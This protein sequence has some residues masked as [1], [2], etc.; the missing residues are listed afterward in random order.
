M[1][2]EG[3]DADWWR[4]REKTERV[5]S[6]KRNEPVSLYV[7]TMRTYL[8]IMSDMFC[9]VLEPFCDEGMDLNREALREVI[10]AINTERKNP[11]WN[12]LPGAVRDFSTGFVEFARALEK[13]GDEVLAQHRSVIKSQYSLFTRCHSYGY[14]TG[15]NLERNT[16]FCVKKI[17]SAYRA[18]MKAKGEGVDGVA[19]TASVRAFM[20]PKG[21]CERCPFR[22]EGWFGNLKPK[23]TV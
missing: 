8:D 18:A 21:Y 12:N 3:Q 19:F 1:E 7:R 14:C 4:G 5:P 6:Q 22:L 9:K 23:G 16:N 10:S 15:Q 20:G 11:D 17:N 13:A 2:F